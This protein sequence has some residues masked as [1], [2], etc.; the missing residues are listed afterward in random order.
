MIQIIQRK[1]KYNKKNWIGRSEGAEVNFQIKDTDDTLLIYT[2]RPDT[3]YGATYM[4]VAPEHEIIEKY[5]DKITNLEEVENYKKQASL[6]SDFER[7]ELNKEKSGVEIK[8]I[9]SSK[10]FYKKK[11]YQLDFRL[12]INYLWYR[13][14]YGCSCT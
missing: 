9:K 1:L 7:S 6:K 5:K 11:K 13:S 2:T 4:V 12:C 14:Y 3:I 8:G 10:S